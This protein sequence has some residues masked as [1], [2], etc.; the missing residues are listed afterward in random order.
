MTTSAELDEMIANVKA[1]LYAI[2]PAYAPDYVPENEESL[3]NAV[4]FKQV[5]WTGEEP[6]HDD[7]V[8]CPVCK[9][10][11]PFTFGVGRPASY[12]SNACKMKAYRQRQKPLRK[13]QEKPLRNALRLTEEKPLLSIVPSHP[14]QNLA[15]FL[16][17]DKTHKV[18]KIPRAVW[19][20]PDEQVI[21]LG[22]FI[23]EDGQIHQHSVNLEPKQLDIL[24]DIKSFND[25]K[26]FLGG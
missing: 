8:A 12:C 23:G 5:D 2:N 15:P 14:L 25:L 17:P 9:G 21:A 4:T 3:R 10:V 19:D 1:A 22:Y 7:S 24:S 16:D 26:S 6:V 11:M 13:L 20:L 18:F